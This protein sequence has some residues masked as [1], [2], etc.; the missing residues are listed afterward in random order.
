M[1]E[2]G[3]VLRERGLTETRTASAKGWL[4]IRIRTPLDTEQDTDDELVGTQAQ[5]GSDVNLDA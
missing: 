5:E 3:K 4:G 2:F 1:R